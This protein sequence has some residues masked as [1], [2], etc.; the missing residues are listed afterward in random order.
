[1]L[2]IVCYLRQQLLLLLP[3]VGR[4]HTTLDVHIY[5]TYTLVT[6]PLPSSGRHS[7]FRGGNSP[8]PPAP[9]SF[10]PLFRSQQESR[11]QTRFGNLDVS[12]IAQSMYT[13]SAHVQSSRLRVV[14]M[15]DFYGF[16]WKLVFVAEVEPNKQIHVPKTFLPIITFQHFLSQEI[17]L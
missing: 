12:Y 16:W 13:S 11:F 15:V 8:P 3:T 5:Y 1:M 17:T 9:P 7:L 10:P 6:I 4:Q 14:D 2:R